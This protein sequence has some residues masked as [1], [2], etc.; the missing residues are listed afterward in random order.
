MNANTKKYLSWA[1]M[2]GAVIIAAPAVMSIVKE[3][4]EPK[5]IIMPAIV[6]LVAITA[7]TYAYHENSM[8]ASP[9]AA[10]PASSTPAPSAPVATPA[11]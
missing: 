2:G 1:T 9:V 3:Y 7:F 11:A 8:M 10:A 5:K 4:K 6:V